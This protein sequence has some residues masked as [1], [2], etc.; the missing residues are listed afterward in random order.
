MLVTCLLRPK[1]LKQSEVKWLS[2]VRLLVT[3]WTVAYQASQ[4][5]KF[6]R[7]EYWSVLPFP[8]TGDL[9][10]LGIEPRSSTLQADTL[11]SEPPGKPF[12]YLSKGVLKMPYMKYSYIL[13]YIPVSLVSV[14][15][16]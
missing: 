13:D 4:S 16:K 9:P 1:I 3:P 8:S 12:A 11:P 15:L 10:N 6:F 2:H 7:Q 14:F 5:M